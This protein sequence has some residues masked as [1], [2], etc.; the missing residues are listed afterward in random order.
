MKIKKNKIGGRSY[1]KEE[2]YIN[3]KG[4]DKTKKKKNRSE[5][6]ILIIARLKP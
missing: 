6:V 5:E 4:V 3:G 1:N 2:R